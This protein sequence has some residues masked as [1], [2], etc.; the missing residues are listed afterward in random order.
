MTVNSICNVGILNVDFN[1]F[2]TCLD[3]NAFKHF[4][5][6]SLRRPNNRFIYGNNVNKSSYM[7][8]YGFNLLFMC[9]FNVILQIINKYFVWID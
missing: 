1:W 9:L 8:I 2:L 7:H 6:F 4:S 3:F 5:Q